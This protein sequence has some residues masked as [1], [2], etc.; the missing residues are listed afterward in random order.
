M[1]RFTMTIIDRI[2][3]VA[4]AF[5]F[6]QF[7]LFMQYYTH[8][9]IGHV[10]ELQWQV[11]TMR[12]SASMVGKSL[13]QYISKFSSHADSDFSLQGKMMQQTLDRWHHFSEGLQGMQQA[14]VWEKPFLFLKN[15]DL[16][17]ATTTF[18]AYQPAIPTSLEG[19]IYAL[20][21]LM[22]GFSFFWLIKKG[23]TA[24]FYKS[25]PSIGSH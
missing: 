23:T 16:S 20:L 14:T 25:R 11:S 21:G 1:L 22:A 7:P 24:C 18:E 19:G 10:A 4:G 12:H 3:A 9:L 5:L 2:C 8:Q 15:F 17:I 13:D 6:S